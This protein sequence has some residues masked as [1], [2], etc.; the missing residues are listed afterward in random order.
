MGSFNKDIEQDIKGN[1]FVYFLF[2]SSNLLL[3]L[4]ALAM[5]SAG[6]Y[7]WIVTSSID[8]FSITF[9]ALGKYLAILKHNTFNIHP[10]KYT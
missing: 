9:M 3:I 6:V 5:I 1:C 7:L 4:E 10:F 2:T 8:V